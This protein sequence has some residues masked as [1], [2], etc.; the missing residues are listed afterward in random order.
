MPRIIQTLKPL[1][2][3]N[4]EKTP[5]VLNS[6]CHIDALCEASD[7]LQFGIEMDDTNSQTCE[8]SIT[9]M[10]EALTDNGW[11]I[12]ESFDEVYMTDFEDLHM[13]SLFSQK[14]DSPSP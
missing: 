13:M 11:Y 12:E 3:N 6:M 5:V 14:N 9:L 10:K 4:T 7:L 1:D 2:N 8:R